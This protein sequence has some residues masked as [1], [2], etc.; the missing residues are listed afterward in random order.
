MKPSGLALV[1]ILCL[2]PWIWLPGIA[3]GRDTL[4]LI[5][6]YF[7]MVAIIAMA[8]S[9]TIATRWPGV[10]LVFG[11]LDKNYKLHKWLGIG[12]LVLSFLHDTIDADMRGLGRATALTD[13][14][15]TAGEISYNGLIILILI[16]IATFIPYHLWKWT[17]RLIGIFFVLAAFHY[18]F[19]LKPYSNGDPL[20]L[21]MAAICVIGCIAYAYTSAP[22]RFRPSRDYKITSVNN[23]GGALAVEMQPQGKPLRHRAGQFAFFSFRGAGLSE[24][25]PFT[26]SSA[27]RDDGSL[28][29]TVADLGDYTSRVRRML[30]VGQEVAVEGPFGHFGAGPRKKPQIWVAAGVGI[31][32]FV[33]LAEA[34]SDDGPA[35]NLIFAVRTLD[36]APHLAALERLA[37]AKPNLMLTVWESAERGR[38][39]ADKIAAHL[40]GV[41]GQ[42]VLFCGPAAMRKTLQDGMVAQGVSR[43]NVH[44]E[45]FEIRTG[46]GLKRFANWLWDQRQKRAAAP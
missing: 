1:A 16:T 44:Y 30:A 22:R 10:E 4:A 18:L 13:A 46:L 38:L 45:L 27:P 17:H 25:H 14:A 31:T 35:V 23:D 7:G 37:A 28:R 6:Q 33:A 32:P 21:Y 34:L 41:S 8:I 3:A 43:R 40:G 24:P 42:K 9:Q 19:I 12:A 36:Q 2:I 39:T 29:V 15:E 26:I 20:G 5:S 11:P